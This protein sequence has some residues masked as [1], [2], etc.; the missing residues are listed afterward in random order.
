MQ[1]KN[2][3]TVYF[4]WDA[5]FGGVFEKVKGKFRKLYPIQ[6]DGATPPNILALR[7]AVNSLPIPVKIVD[8]RVDTAKY[9]HIQDEICQLVRYDFSRF[10]ASSAEYFGMIDADDVKSFQDLVTVKLEASPEAANIIITSICQTRGMRLEEPE[11]LF[12]FLAY[13]IRN[14][15]EQYTTDFLELFLTNSLPLEV[16]QK[17]TKAEVDYNARYNLQSDPILPMVKIIEKDSSLD[18]FGVKSIEDLQQGVADVQLVP[19][20]PEAVRRVFGRAKALYIFGYFRY[21]FFT[22]SDHYAYLA[23]ESAI[24]NK[25][26]IS[27]G[28]KAVLTNSKTDRSFEMVL[29]SWEGILRFCIEQ[30][31]STGIVKVNGQCFPF[32]MDRL[33]NWLVKSKIITEWERAQYDPYIQL[34]NILSHLEYAPVHGPSL[35]TLRLTAT[36]INKLFA[37]F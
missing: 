5:Y 2:T 9:E 11:S 23:L 30:K 10:G 28:G 32:N 4:D 7:D 21:E 3:K 17:F 19:N 1:L 25:Y 29:P 14:N 6:D 37:G 22:I 31:W 24:K 8:V 20:I 26:A 33:L 16:M 27:L 34:R 12:H 13:D 36:K 35:Q 15:L 18:I